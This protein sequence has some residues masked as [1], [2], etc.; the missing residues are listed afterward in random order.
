M[1]RTLDI[2]EAAAFLHMHKDTVQRRAKAG[3]IPGTKP[4]RSWV[5]LE[6]DLV[7]YLKRLQTQPRQTGKGETLCSTNV[8]TP[9]GWISS[10]QA[11]RELDALL[12]QRT[13]QPHRSCTTVS[14]Q[15]AGASHG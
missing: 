1:V 7:A 4:G 11:A 6:E 2:H 13:K 12:A 15:K 3:E 10:H 14:R 5:F 8:V 9:G